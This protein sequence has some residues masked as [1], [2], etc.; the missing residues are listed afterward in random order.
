MQFIWSTIPSLQDQK[1]VWLH[2]R[3]VI[4]RLCVWSMALL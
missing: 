3:K 2:A 4:V 1:G